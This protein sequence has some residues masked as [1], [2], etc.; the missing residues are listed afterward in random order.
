[1]S[2][3]LGMSN[4]GLLQ[5]QVKIDKLAWAQTSSPIATPFALDVCGHSDGLGIAV[6]TRTGASNDQLFAKRMEKTI[7]TLAQESLIPQDMT[8]ADLVKMIEN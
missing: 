3:S 4:L 8:L 1:M 2:A 5:V 6:S 7:L